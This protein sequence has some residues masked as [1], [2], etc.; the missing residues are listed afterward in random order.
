MLTKFMSGGSDQRLCSAYSGIACSLVAVE[1]SEHKMFP[2]ICLYS[3]MARSRP[4]TQ[5]ETG[6]EQKHM[7]KPSF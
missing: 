2:L 4:T 3:A 6:L 5:S 7:L 1:P